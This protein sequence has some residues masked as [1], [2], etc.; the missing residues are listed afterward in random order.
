MYYDIKYC[1][2]FYDNDVIYFTHP[3]AFIPYMV[4]TFSV[5]HVLAKWL[6]RQGR[7]TGM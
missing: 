6:E 4:M 1:Q 7:D 3:V 5:G 2:E